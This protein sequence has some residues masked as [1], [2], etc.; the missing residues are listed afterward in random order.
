MSTCWAPHSRV[1]RLTPVALVL[2]IRVPAIVVEVVPALSD[3]PP[4]GILADRL[5]ADRTGLL[6]LR[7]GAELLSHADVQRARCSWACRL[8]TYTRHGSSSGC[9]EIIMYAQVSCSCRLHAP[10]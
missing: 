8:T 3:V 6:F 9:T 5:Q 10:G 7:S 2:M 1:V 4:H